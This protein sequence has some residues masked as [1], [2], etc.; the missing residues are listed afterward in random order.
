[1][2]SKSRGL[3]PGARGGPQGSSLSTVDYSGHALP[4]QFF[5]THQ[6]R[7]WLEESLRGMSITTPGPQILVGFVDGGLDRTSNWCRNSTQGGWVT[8]WAG[9]VGMIAPAP[10]FTLELMEPEAFTDEQRGCARAGRVL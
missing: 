1:V 2:A 3:L 5:A 7:D 9:L 10:V 4:R 6:S 8:G